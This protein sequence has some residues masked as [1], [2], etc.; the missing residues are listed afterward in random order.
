[1]GVYDNDVLPAS[2]ALVRFEHELPD[3]SLWADAFRREL[4]SNVLAV[5]GQATDWAIARMAGQTS[6][7][8]GVIKS[9]GMTVT[10]TVKPFQSEP[11]TMERA[12]VLR[13]LRTSVTAWKEIGNIGQ[14]AGTLE[15]LSYALWSPSGGGYAATKLLGRIRNGMYEAGERLR[16]MRLPRVYGPAAPTDEPAPREEKKMVGPL[17][18]FIATGLIISL[19]G[20]G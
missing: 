15:R 11:L 6:E 20:R 17:V 13:I 10:D 18:A 14:N 8:S 16:T 2:M 1:M 9:I 12:D 5:A 4:I 3:E 7:V 19:V